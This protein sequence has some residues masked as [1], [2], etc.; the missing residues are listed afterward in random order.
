[1]YAV[2]PAARS[3]RRFGGFVVMAVESTTGSGEP[4]GVVARS[5]TRPARTETPHGITGGREGRT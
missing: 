2:E 3:P 5:S 4:D 1:M